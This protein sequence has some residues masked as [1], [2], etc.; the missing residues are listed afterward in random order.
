MQDNVKQTA[1]EASQTGLHIQILDG[2]DVLPL[3]LSKA[4]GNNANFIRLYNIAADGTETAITGGAV[5]SGAWTDPSLRELKA[6]MK[7]LTDNQIEKIL[8]KLKIYRFRYADARDITYVSPEAEEFHQLTGWGDGE[9]LPPGTIAGIALR[10]VQWVY[11][12]V[13][14]FDARLTALETKAADD[15]PSV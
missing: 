3:K 14:E 6:D 9:S 8:N 2:R 15:A 7:D 10:C 5:D 13:L 4:V 12:K 11:K 1:D